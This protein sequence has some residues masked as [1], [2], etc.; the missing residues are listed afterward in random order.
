M[1]YDLEFR[2]QAGSQVDFYVD[3]TCKGTINTNLP[4]GVTNGYLLCMLSIKN[5]AAADKTI[6]FSY[7]DFWQ[8][9]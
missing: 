5:T 2:W 8:S 1:A 6:Y 9:A 4:S 3:G 7:W